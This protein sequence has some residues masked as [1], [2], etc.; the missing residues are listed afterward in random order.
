MAQ[1]GLPKSVVTPAQLKTRQNFLQLLHSFAASGKPTLEDEQVLNKSFPAYNP[2]VWHGVKK[3]DD[4]REILE[5]SESLRMAN[6]ADKTAELLFWKGV[7][8]IF[9]AITLISL[10][11]TCA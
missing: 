3:E 11:V 4:R 10:K 7:K 8:M 9:Q 1:F 2:K 5:I 6:R